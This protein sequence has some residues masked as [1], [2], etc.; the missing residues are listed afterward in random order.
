M[1]FLPVLCFSRSMVS[2]SWRAWR[3]ESPSGSCRPY[4]AVSEEGLFS[5]GGA[6]SA[7]RTLIA[8]FAGWYGLRRGRSGSAGQLVE[9]VAD[10][11]RLLINVNLP[12]VDEV[13]TLSCAPAI[14]GARRSF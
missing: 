14:I 7:M 5:A 1:R 3:R 10:L 2:Y 8:N 4:L 12:G 6:L 13:L 9:H 11:G